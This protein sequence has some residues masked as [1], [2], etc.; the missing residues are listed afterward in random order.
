MSSKLTC[1]YI[2]SSRAGRATQRDSYLGGGGGRKDLGWVVQAANPQT[3]E[4]NLEWG[5]DQHGRR[6]IDE[7]R[8]LHWIFGGKALS[9]L[10]CQVE[11]PAS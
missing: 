5:M 7:M 8:H 6:M 9:K 1:P 4:G 10:P 2:V 3:V 11:R